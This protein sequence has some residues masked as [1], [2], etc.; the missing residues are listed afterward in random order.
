MQFSRFMTASEFLRQLGELRAFRGYMGTG[1][2]ESLEATGLLVPRLR[3]RYPDPIA[4][5]FWLLMHPERPRS[6]KH[7]I[8][9]DGPRWDAALEFDKAMHRSQN[10]IVYGLA[11]NPLDDPEAR[12]SGFI[13]RPSPESFVPHLD[14]RVDVSNELEET[15]FADNADDRYST[16]QLLLAAEQADAGVYLRMN[17]ENE[18]IF[19]VAYD[20][21]GKGRLP[22][23]VGY[24]LNIETVHAARDFKKHTPT[25]D[26]VVWF[27]EERWRALSNII[28]GQGGRFRLSAAQSSQYESDS[29]SLA[30]EACRRFGVSAD[31][32][33]ELIRCFAK[34]WSDW[35]REGRPL[36]AGA[37]KEFLEPAVLLARR[38][39]G[40]T[41]GEVR[42]QVGAVGGWNTPALDLISPDWAKEEK[43][44]ASL[45]LQSNLAGRAG[46][47]TQA[48]I[49][50]FVEFLASEGLEAV[51][52]RLKSFE[53]HALRG[54]EFAIEAM[55]SDIQGMAVVV[56]HVAA[57][58]G[59]DKT[60]LDDKFRQ[61][62][63]NPE[64]ARIINRG[65][66]IPLGRQKRLADD[67]PALKARID[68]L[69]I[70][71][72]GDTAADLVMAYRIRGGV[73]TLLP[74]D[75]HLELEALFT[76]LMR[77]ALLTF[78][79]VRGHS[80]ETAAAA[81]LAS[82]LI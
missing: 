25:L 79:E 10:W 7:P 60:Q 56:E 77:A 19:R 65:D 16:W 81:A 21:L 5:R 78:I 44:R 23:G 3:I 74:E 40:L 14:L 12:F 34:R 36:I 38:A 15:L 31:D 6:L 52:W 72:G 51:F 62:W 20:A 45:T 30:T 59:A 43:A 26:S 57:T 33:I 50:A 27:V 53:D 75:D 55:K 58:L 47:I 80:T 1:L 64:V 71:P 9:P 67:W 54:N 42:D 28:K 35:N 4:R 37:Y 32:L 69:R 11:R 24:T 8:E 13:Q 63:R 46:S 68:A 48:D 82:I 22:E 70:E 2:L 29:Q 18:R 49:K 41:F 17:L 76:G 39:G 66:V 61:L 73:H